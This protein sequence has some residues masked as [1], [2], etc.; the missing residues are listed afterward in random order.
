MF[1]VSRAAALARCP[2]ASRALRRF[3]DAPSQ[4]L[5]TRRLGGS[6]LSVTVLGQ[7]GAPLGDLY[8]Q[9]SHAQAEACLEAA[10]AAGITLYDTSPWYGLGLSEMRFGLALH[11]KPRDS[12]VLQ[13]KLGRDLL[14]RA[15]RTARDAGF[16]RGLRFSYRHEYTAEAFARLERGA[17]LVEDRGA[18]ALRRAGPRG[19]AQERAQ[20]VGTQAVCVRHSCWA[21][22]QNSLWGHVRT[23]SRRPLGR[24]RNRNRRTRGTP[25]PK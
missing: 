4:H 19:R 13:T 11:R 14:P 1:I 18:E 22:L 2:R 21:D 16:A 5:R 23:M 12:F 3:A 24:A 8:E 17:Q 10:H 9:I 6:E 7:G 25:M 20:G 15:H